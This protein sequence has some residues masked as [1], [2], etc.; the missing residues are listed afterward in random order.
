MNAG[1]VIA[2]FLDGA[3]IAD[4]GPDA[5]RIIRSELALCA[6]ALASALDGGGSVAGA[7]AAM[8]DDMRDA[9]SD[10]GQGYEAGREWAL[11]RAQL[12]MTQVLNTILAAAMS[13]PQ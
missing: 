8:L 6:G 10:W 13:R 11:H 5:E 2:R 1:E 12:A 7:T 4:L 3:A 9:Q